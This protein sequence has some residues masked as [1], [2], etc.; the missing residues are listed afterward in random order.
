M[1]AKLYGS[2]LL[3]TFPM[4]FFLF[5]VLIKEC[6][7]KTDIIF[8]LDRSSSIKPSDYDEMRKF[9]KMIGKRLKIGER[10]EIGEILGQ[11]ALV[12]FSERGEKRL[13]LAE[14]VEAG[15]FVDVVE[16]MPGPLPGG[17]TKT[18]LGLNVA[19]KEVV[20]KV[21]GYRADD[22]DVKKM[23]M[24]ITDGEQTRGGRGFTYVGDAMK[25][26]FNRAMDV[27]AIGVGLKEQKAI[28]EVKDMVNVKENAILPGN[29]T[30]LVNQVENII[31]KFCPSKYII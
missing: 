18:H 23:I 22:P 21:A 14:S 30:D 24:V 20:I 29:Y 1:Q 26:F 12:T 6:K 5:L 19:D 3:L 7:K 16:T 10:N 13:T 27:F 15:K 17:R 11:G 31:R 9:L 8:V 2:N 4:T 28:D 25:P